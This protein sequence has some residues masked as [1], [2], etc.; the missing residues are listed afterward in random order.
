MERR[1]ELPGSISG[2]RGEPFLLVSRT[3]ARWRLTQASWSLRTASVH[4]SPEVRA[5]APTRT[6][7]PPFS[8]CSHTNRGT[9]GHRFRTLAGREG[10]ERVDTRRERTRSSVARLRRY[11]EPLLVD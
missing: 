1:H 4:F 2:G 8:A 11:G 6:G 5:I 9:G 7:E 3:P 10:G